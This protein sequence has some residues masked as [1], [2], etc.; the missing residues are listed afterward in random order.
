MLE[1]LKVKHKLLAVTSDSA[2][3]NGTLVNHLYTQLLNE[4]NDKLDEDFGNLKPLMQFQ[5]RKSYIRCLAHALNLIVKDILANLKSKTMEATKAGE[6]DAKK[7]SPIAKLQ[8]I[9]V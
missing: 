3:N 6:V 1:D 5:G 4:F 9:V 7:A 2:S 8:H